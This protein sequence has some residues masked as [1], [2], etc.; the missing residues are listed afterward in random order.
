M[1]FFNQKD[2]VIDIKLTQYGK[3]LLSQGKFKPMYYSF[4]D[5]D[6]LYNSE[7]GGIIEHQNNAETR[8]K[9][10][11]P[12]LKVQHNYIG[13]ETQF[14]QM[15]KINDYKNSQKFIVSKTNESFAK[16][17]IQ[18]TENKFFAPES[19]VG[20]TRVENKYNPSWD[21]KFYNENLKGVSKILTSSASP[22]VKIPQ[23][24]AEIEFKTY[25]TNDADNV[26]LPWS[27]API[28]GEFSDDQQ[29][30]ETGPLEF[31]DGS[32]IFLSEDFILIGIDEKNT[33]FFNENFEIEIFMEE[34]PE[35]SVESTG[36]TDDQ[37]TTTLVP[38][39]F[40]AFEKEEDD[41]TDID[42]FED[43][44]YVEYFFDVK[45]DQDIP[46]NI[47]CG[48]VSEDDK[49]SLYVKQ[50]FKCDDPDNKTIHGNIYKDDDIGE[51]CE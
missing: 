46:L 2:E 24:E 50:I 32:A 17:K 7:F 10:E 18:E 6:I 42:L 11:T 16:T 14:N 43:T 35:G 40:A 20:N 4:F 51:P 41:S 22:N 47:L 44:S 49:K 9:D 38:L 34:T 13:V 26:N 48:Y 31:E 19:S 23:L 33:E 5:K 30:L 29:L 27:S 3:R 37:K 28:V 12:R 45:L 8:I 15:K 1:E 36:L 21:V 39:K 25:M